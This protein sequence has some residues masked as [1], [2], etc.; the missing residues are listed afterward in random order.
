MSGLAPP[1]YYNFFNARTESTGDIKERYSTYT[2]CANNIN[3]FKDYYEGVAF[4]KERN[5]PVFLDFTGYGCVNCRKT[6]EHIWIDDNVMNKLN[7]EFV[8][9]S[10]YV[11]DRKSLE[12]ILIS[13][14]T[15][16]KLR[17]VGNIWSDFQIVNFEQNSQPLY[18]MMTPD[19]QVMAA[20][21]GYQEGIPGYIDFLDCGL[22]TFNKKFKK[23]LGALD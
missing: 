14:N 18:V 1:A 2:K 16:K 20:P 5:L 11:D 7:D 13:L 9:V 6:E 23:K 19:E 10:L 8:L 15:Q 17:N 12:E 4:A 21:R 3:C 22:E